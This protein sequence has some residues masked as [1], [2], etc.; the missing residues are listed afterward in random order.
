MQREQIVGAGGL[1]AA[2][3]A[4]SSVSSSRDLRAFLLRWYRAV[5]SLL[6]CHDTVKRAVK[7][8]TLCDT[9]LKSKASKFH[10]LQPTVYAVRDSVCHALVIGAISS[11]ICHCHTSSI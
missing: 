10:N 8:M 2:M 5:V 7:L 11:L 9:N 3:N 4:I 1:N 6:R